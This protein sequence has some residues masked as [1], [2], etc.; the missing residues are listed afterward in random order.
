M[1]G[2]VEYGSDGIG[3]LAIAALGKAEAGAYSVE[4]SNVHGTIRCTAAVHIG[5]GPQEG[6]PP[7]F[8]QGLQD[9]TLHVCF[10]IRL[11][12][13][14]HG[15]LFVTGRSLRRGRLANCARCMSY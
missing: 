15:C 11:R 13:M 6:R 1:L 10:L 5:A 3:S 14:L 7:V 8:L 12:D 4:A 2:Q 9:Q